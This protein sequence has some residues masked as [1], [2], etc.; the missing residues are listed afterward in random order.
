MKIIIAHSKTKRE[1][2][3]AFDL[4]GSRENLKRVA[5]AINDEISES[6]FE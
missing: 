2:C 1:I 6:K 5:D 3:G 4:C